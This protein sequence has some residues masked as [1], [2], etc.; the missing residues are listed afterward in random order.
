MS[1]LPKSD[2]DWIAGVAREGVV[3]IGDLRLKAP[4]AQVTAE[5]ARPL[6]ESMVDRLRALSGAGLAAPQVGASV[7]VAVVE[8]RRTDEFPDRPEHPLISMINPV[9]VNRSQDEIDDWEGCFSVPGLMGK[10]PRAA[11]I[12]VEYTTP[13]GDYVTED[14]AGYV[15]RTIQHEIDHLDAIEFVDRMPDMSTLTTVQN[16]LANRA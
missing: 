9:I 10:V 14:Y 16:W 2:R 11:H 12:T 7:K 1:T 8:V 15:A 3:T 4:T 5:E 13:D 6:V